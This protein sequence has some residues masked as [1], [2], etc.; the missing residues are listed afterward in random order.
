LLGKH[1]PCLPFFALSIFLK[2]SCAFTW[3]DLGPHSSYLSLLHR[4]D[5]RYAPPHL[6][7][8][9]RWGLPNFLPGLPWNCY[10]DLCLAGNW[11]YRDE[12]LCLANIHLFIASRSCQSP[13][14][15]FSILFIFTSHRNF[16]SKLYLFMWSGPGGQ[17]KWVD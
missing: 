3:G 15:H 11:E 4:W 1:L 14:L 9:L 12:P 17:S 13:L 16:P 2:G 6:A 8:L 10:P 5:C 7:Y